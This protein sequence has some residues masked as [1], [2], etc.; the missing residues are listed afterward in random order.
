VI[1]EIEQNRSPIGEDEEITVGEKMKKR[2]KIVFF[3][4]I[5][6]LRQ[7]SEIENGFSRIL[8]VK[9]VVE[10][11]SSAD[12]DNPTIGKNL[13]G[14]IPPARGEIRSVLNP[15]T[16]NASNSSVARCENP[17]S[18]FAVAITAGLD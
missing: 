16:R 4:R 1:D 12:D 6:R 15:I 17:Y 9:L 5:S 13:I 3:I 11:S 8:G 10:S 2:I 14:G 18:S 7:E